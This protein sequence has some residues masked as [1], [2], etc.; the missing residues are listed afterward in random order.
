[1]RRAAPLS[2]TAELTIVAYTGG[3]KARRLARRLRPRSLFADSRCLA[4]RNGQVV[5]RCRRR[6]RCGGAECNSERRGSPGNSNTWTWARS[7]VDRSDGGRKEGGI[8]AG[9]T[10]GVRQITSQHAKTLASQLSRLEGSLEVF[11][12]RAKSPGSY[13]AQYEACRWRNDTISSSCHKE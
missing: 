2:T 7:A 1:M 8:C 6:Q 3:I 10:V 5:P 12:T 4:C 11:R 9:R 13:S